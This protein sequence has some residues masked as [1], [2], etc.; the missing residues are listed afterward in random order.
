MVARYAHS[1]TVYEL[2][3]QSVSVQAHTGESTGHL[4]VVVT[5]TIHLVLLLTWNLQCNNDH[6][7]L[8]QPEPVRLEW[9]SHIIFEVTVARQAE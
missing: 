9:R 7:L 6:W 2:T 8:T 3:Y 1:D 4:V 5:V